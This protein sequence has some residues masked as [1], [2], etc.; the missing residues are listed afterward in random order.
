MAT[1][2]RSLFWPPF[3]SRRT[4]LVRHGTRPSSQHGT[5]GAAPHRCV[6]TAARDGAPSFAKNAGKDGS[7][8]NGSRLLL[9]HNET[10]VLYKTEP[11]YLLS[12]QQICISG[13]ASARRMLTFSLWRLVERSV[14]RPVPRFSA[15]F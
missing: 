6:P 12:E 7:P 11:S 2:L 5:V 3:R 13:S 14:R 15:A 4:A 9:T 8:A 1:S 10:H